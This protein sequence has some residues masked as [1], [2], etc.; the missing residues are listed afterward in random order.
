M[1]EGLGAHVPGR[2]FLKPVISHR[3]RRIETLLGVTRFKQSLLRGMMPPYPGEAISLKLQA[4]GS[5]VLAL[6]RTPLPLALIVPEE[7]LDV[8]T[9]FMRDDVGL[10]EVPRRAE[11][12]L[13]LLIEGEI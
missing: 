4:D 7:M 6:Y 1:G 10:G 5:A 3:C 2:C 9:Q 12:L 11:T 8:V 13:Q